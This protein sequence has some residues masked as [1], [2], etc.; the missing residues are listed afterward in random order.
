MAVDMFITIGDIKGESIDDK[1]KDQ[2]EV[3]SWSWGMTQTG[4][5]HAGQGGG[6]GKVDV[7]NLV[8]T[9]YIDRASPALIKWCCKGTHF[10]KAILTVRKAGGDALEYLKIE[11]FNG[12]ISQISVG[13]AGGA[14]RLTEN[15]GLN[16]AAFKYAY[17]PQTSKGAGDAVVPASWN[18]AKNTETV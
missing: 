18:I 12:L 1:H 7:Q 10:D 13:G 4:T 5:S 16:F 3:L 14:E 9:K 8:F 11:L 2:I 15:I 17:T 6:I